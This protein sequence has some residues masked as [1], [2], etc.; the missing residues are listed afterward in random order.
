M[1]KFIVA[2]TLILLAAPATPVQ[3]AQN[4]PYERCLARGDR[5]DINTLTTVFVATAIAPTSKSDFGV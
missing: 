2:M 3:S 5:Y 1:K 4:T